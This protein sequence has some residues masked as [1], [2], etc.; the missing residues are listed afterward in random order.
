MEN[1]PRVFVIA[2]D[3]VFT[4]DI[5]IT[6]LT[7]IVEAIFNRKSRANVVTS[8][9]HTISKGLVKFF[10]HISRAN[11]VT[12]TLALSSV[13]VQNFQLHIRL[14]N[15]TCFENC[16]VKNGKNRFASQVVSLS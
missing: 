2:L 4:N 13:I 11:F 12:G 6:W 8:G 16:M 9:T 3:L 1:Q 5:G 7:R 10:N 15:N 14:L